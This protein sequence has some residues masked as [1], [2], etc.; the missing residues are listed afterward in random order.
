MIEEMAQRAKP[1]L[2][3]PFIRRTRRNHGLEHATVSLLSRKFRGSPLMGRSSDRGF[4]LFA[5]MPQGDVEEAVHEALRRMKSGEHHLAVH[6]GCGTSR[7]TTG[8]LTSLVAIV[9]LSGVRL[10]NAFSRLPYLM[11]LMMLTVLVAEPLGLALQR[12]FTTDGNPA[13]L[14]VLEITQRRAR[15]PL[16]FQPINLYTIRT[17]SS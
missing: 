4:I 10:R 9:S 3:L 2:D 16:T 5:D 7:L 14:E 12:H 17:R 1:I 6:P 11:L 15:L 8:I 13:D